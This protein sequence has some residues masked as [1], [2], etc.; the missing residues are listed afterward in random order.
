M[1]R[2]ISKVVFVALIYIGAAIITFGILDDPAHDEWVYLKAF[3]ALIVWSTF[4]GAIVEHIESQ[5]H[6]H[7]NNRKRN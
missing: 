6:K 7:G 4:T 5:Q 2:T 1:Y 3:C